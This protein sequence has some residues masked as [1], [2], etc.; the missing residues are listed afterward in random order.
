[1]P[2]I[3]LFLGGVVCLVLLFALLRAPSA[4]AESLQAAETDLDEE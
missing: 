1:M 3:T 2:D 4:Q